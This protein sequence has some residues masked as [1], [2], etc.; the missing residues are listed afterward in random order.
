[1][2]VGEKMWG[3]AF[4]SATELTRSLHL[5]QLRSLGYRGRRCEFNTKHQSTL[6]NERSS[7]GGIRAGR[8]SPGIERLLRARR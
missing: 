3:V 4:L 6:R 7:W 8:R 1:M 2:D 5:T